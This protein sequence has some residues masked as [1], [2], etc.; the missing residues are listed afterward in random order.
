M[1]TSRGSIPIKSSIQILLGEKNSLRLAML[2]GEVKVLFN[3]CGDDALYEFKVYLIWMDTR[4][5]TALRNSSSS[6]KKKNPNVRK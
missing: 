1:G 2:V 6:K 3:L 4:S 5:G